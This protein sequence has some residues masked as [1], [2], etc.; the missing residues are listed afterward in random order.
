MRSPGLR[1]VTFNSTLLPTFGFLGVAVAATPAPSATGA[2]ASAHTS[3][4][5]ARN[6]FE[7][8]IVRV[9][10]GS[11]PTYQRFLAVAIGLLVVPGCGDKDLDKPLPAV[12]KSLQVTL[13]WTNGARIPQPYTCDGVGRKP[14][15]NIAGA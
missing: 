10:L 1:P 13:P 15:V 4:T 7:M 5:R 6:L 3:A 11:V 8:A 2:I 14:F 9:L 12:T